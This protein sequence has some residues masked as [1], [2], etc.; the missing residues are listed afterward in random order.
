MQLILAERIAR[1]RG[2]LATYE[3]NLQDERKVADYHALLDSAVQLE[4]RRKRA[5]AADGGS[6]PM[7]DCESAIPA[8]GTMVCICD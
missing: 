2:Q 4:R 6:A 5:S 7:D 1:H 8:R 3:R